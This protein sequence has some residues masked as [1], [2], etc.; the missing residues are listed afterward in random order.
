MDSPIAGLPVALRLALRDLKNNWLRALSFGVLLALALS[1]LLPGL[2]A[3]RL[4]QIIGGATMTVEQAPAFR[5]SSTPERKLVAVFQ[6]VGGSEADFLANNPRVSVFEE[7][8][9]VPQIAVTFGDPDEPEGGQMGIPVTSAL[10]DQA[11][12]AQTVT[13]LAGRTPTRTGE[14][15]LDPETV[16]EFPEVAALFAGMQLGQTRT[17]N[18]TNGP[19]DLT[20]VGSL[21]SNLP[22]SW[23]FASPLVVAP[24][25]FGMPDEHG[26]FP[27]VPSGLFG[28]A[29]GTEEL[30]MAAAIRLGESFAGSYEPFG[31][32]VATLSMH[33][34]QEFEFLMSKVPGQQSI[35]GPDYSMATLVLVLMFIAVIGV[36]MFTLSN[37][38]RQEEMVALRKAGASSRTLWAS[39]VTAAFLVAGGAVVVGILGAFIMLRL[40]FPFL[41]LNIVYAS[42][43]IAAIVGVA[44]VGALSTALVA[45]AIPA[46]FTLRSSNRLSAAQPGSTNAGDPSAPSAPLQLKWVMAILGFGAAYLIFGVVSAGPRVNPNAGLGSLVLGAIVILVGVYFLVPALLHKLVSATRSRSLPLRLAVRELATRQ[47]TT[48]TAIVPVAFVSAFITVVGIIMRQHYLEGFVEFGTP[49]SAYTWDFP[50][51]WVPIAAAAV[52]V[53]LTLSAT[54]FSLPQLRQDRTALHNMGQP[55]SLTARTE[56]AR[57]ALIAGLG[58]LIGSLVGTLIG[59]VILAFRWVIGDSTIAIQPGSLLIWEVFLIAAVLPIFAAYAGGRIMGTLTKPGRFPVP[60]QV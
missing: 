43:H 33:N 35:G 45:A 29:F 37:L 36:P 49:N 56:G 13:V 19:I 53:L 1:L 39:L 51:L 30:D 25:T 38:R 5:A 7:L 57:A 4:N 26:E 15:A 42:E 6:A 14:F 55:G 31:F 9:L 24:G 48:V 44:I 3:P 20:L 46:A 18:T 10:F 60:A 58:I 59:V 27:D 28:L 11:P 47:A 22:L 54:Y 50:L 16:T 2:V 34:A 41:P 52:I 12:L 21:R 17:F 8:V 32:S 40:R 23:S